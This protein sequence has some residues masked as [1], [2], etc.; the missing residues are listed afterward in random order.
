MALGGGAV[1]WRPGR[2]PQPGPPRQRRH[3]RRSPCLPPRQG[4]RPQDLVRSGTRSTRSGERIV[5]GMGRRA[6]HTGGDVVTARRRHPMAEEH[7][8]DGSALLVPGGTSNG[9]L[10]WQRPSPSRP[11]P[12]PPPTRPPTSRR[13]R[14]CRSAECGSGFAALERCLHTVS[15]P[16]ILVRDVPDEVHAA[17]QRRAEQRGQSLQQYLAGELVRL[18]ERPSVDELFARVSRRRGGRVGLDQ[19]A[20]DLVDERAQR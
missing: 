4:Q 19:A 1:W 11:R 16:N 13:C 3:R 20:A 8:G 12:R 5:V 14:S 6:S 15:M 2:N 10:P 7:Y 9:D 18:A 17:L